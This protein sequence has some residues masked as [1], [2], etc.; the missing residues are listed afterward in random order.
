MV[1][2]PNWQE[3]HNANWHADDRIAPATADLNDAVDAAINYLDDPHGLPDDLSY[4]AR[5]LIE[6]IAAARADQ[7]AFDTVRDPLTPFVAPPL[8]EDPLAVALGLVP[9]PGGN[10]SGS[11]LKA[12]RQNAGL[13]PS[14]LARLLTEQGH[15]VR[16]GEI[17]RWETSEA[18]PLAA[19][20][21]Q[22]IALALSVSP[23]DLVDDESSVV[24]LGLAMSKQFRE[25]VRRWASHT[26]QTLAAAQTALMK[27]AAAPARRGTS[28]DDAAVIA[29]LDAFVNARIGE[30]S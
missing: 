12:A 17:A 14:A 27:V 20:K 18:V 1:D 10:L 3:G 22:A 23:S 9:P 11:L 21:I 30:E 6:S 13:K 8:A 7:D 29:S 28:R 19:P 16:A 24:T 15:A 4:T 26:N 2:R 5:S 25:L